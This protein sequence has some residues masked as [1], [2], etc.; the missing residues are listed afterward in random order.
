MSSNTINPK[1]CNYGCN[2]RI[3]WN[4][5]ENAYFEVFSGNRHQCPNRQQQYSNYNNKKATSSFSSP[6]QQ[7]TT[8]KNKPSSYSTNKKSWFKIP[9]PIMSNSL[10]LLQ[11]SIQ[12]IQKKYEILSDIVS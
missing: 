1:P 5:S 11:G 6:S 3:Y 12:Y 8:V 9:N 10:E 7:T 4:T 2:T